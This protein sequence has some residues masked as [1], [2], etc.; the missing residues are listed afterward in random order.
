MFS[1]YLEVRLENVRQAFHLVRRCCDA[2]GDTAYRGASAVGNH[3]I[4]LGQYFGEAHKAIA[5]AY[6]GYTRRFIYVDM[7]NLRY[8]NDNHIG[9]RRFALVVVPPPPH[10]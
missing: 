5:G 8:V 2:G 7:V 3:H 10:P 9:P 1:H 6:S 4:L